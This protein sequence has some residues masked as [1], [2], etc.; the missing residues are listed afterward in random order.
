M[1]L[2]TSFLGILN[3]ANLGHNLG[4]FCGHFFG[5]GVRCLKAQR[6]Q[7]L[8]MYYGVLKILFRAELGLILGLF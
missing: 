3:L 4:V 5:F 8:G 7:I 6:G 2:C 1:P